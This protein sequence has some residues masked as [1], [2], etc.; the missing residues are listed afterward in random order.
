MRLLFRIQSGKSRAG[1][2]FRFAFIHMTKMI[3]RGFTVIFWRNL[4]ELH[5]SGF[6]YSI[7]RPYLT[8]NGRK[9]Y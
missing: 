5:R 6:R 9:P 8:V 1:S 3:F 4:S 2:G 7:Y